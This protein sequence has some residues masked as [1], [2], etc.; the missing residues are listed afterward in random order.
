LWAEVYSLAERPIGSRISFTLPCSDAAARK[1]TG[2]GCSV[3]IDDQCVFGGL[4]KRA[5][6]VKLRCTLSAHP[7]MILR[8]L[9]VRRNDS[10]SSRRLDDFLMVE[11]RHPSVLL[12]PGHAF[13]FQ[14][15]PE[16]NPESLR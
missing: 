15:Q 1:S 8:V 9:P 11:I 12:L 4:F 3:S 13:G 14:N 5:R 10:V 2:P 16:Q 7:K 6:L